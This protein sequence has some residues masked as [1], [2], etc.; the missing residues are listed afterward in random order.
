HVLDTL[1]S[2]AKSFPGHFLPYHGKES[3]EKSDGK[4]SNNVCSGGSSSS[5][6]AAGK[7]SKSQSS[8]PTDFWELLVKLDSISV[9]RKGKG[10]PRTHSSAS[11]S[12][13]EE[14][15]VTSLE[16]SAL[17]QLIQQL[18]HPVVRRSSLLTDRLLR[19][20]ALISLGLPETSDNSS[21]SGTT[22][23]TTNTASNNTQTSSTSQQQI[24]E[25]SSTLEHL[26][27]LAIQVLT[28]KSC[29]E[30]GLED[31]TAL[32]LH[33]SH[34]PP[35]ARDQ[36]LRLLL[37]GAATLGS[38]VATHI[39]ALL[40]DLKAHN[41][42]HPAPPHDEELITHLT[43]KNKKGL[44]QDRFTNECVIISGA[45]KVKPPCELQLA[46][47]SS[48]TS[49]TSSQAFFLR[50]LKVIIQLRDAIRLS[51][52]RKNVAQTSSSNS[53][54]NATSDNQPLTS[55]EQPETAA[56]TDAEGSRNSAQLSAP[57]SVD[58]PMQ[59]ELSAVQVQPAVETLSLQTTSPEIE[60]QSD[61]GHLRSL[62]S[63]PQEEEQQPEMMTTPAVTLD[64]PI[65]VADSAAN[66]SAMPVED[67]S[68][69]TA[70]AMDV[71]VEVADCSD[72]GSL[73]AQ[74]CLD[75]LWSTLSECLVELG[76]TPDTHAVLVLQP[77]VEAFFLVHASAASGE[78][79]ER[80]T[81]QSESREAQLAHLQHE[82]AP[83]S[84]LPSFPVE[85]VEGSS[86]TGG[87][88]K[89]ES[90]VS[91]SEISPDD[92]DKF[93]KF[94]EKHRT[95]LNQILRQSTVHLA[96]GPFS[97][98]VDH[99]RLLDFDIKRKYFRTELERADDGMRREDLAVHVRREHVFED[100]FREL[101][102]RSPDEWKNRFYIVFEGEEGQDA[103]GLLREWYMIISR[104]IF[105]PMYALFCTS[106]GDRV[107]YMI[108]PASHCNSNHL[109][110][111][112][113]VG[114]V[115]A[116]AI[117]DNKL[118]ECYFTRSFY[119]HILGKMVRV[120]DME[121]EDYSFY[122]GLIYL[123]EHNVA[124]LGYELTFSTE[125]QEFGVTEVRDLKPNG[126]NIAVMEET[127]ME[128]IRLVCQMKMTG[129]IRKQL[130]AFLEGFY[131]IIPKRLISIFNEQE[132]ELLI[133]GLPTIDIDDLRTNTEYH[134]YQ[135]NSLQIQWF[136]RALRSFDQAERAKFL[137][138]VTGTSKVPLQG[139][140]ALEGM[141][142][143][144]KFQIH[145]DDR[146]TDR[147]P[148][149]HTCFNQLDLPV[150]ETYDKLR[151]Y[152]LKAIHECAEGFGF[153]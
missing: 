37:Q 133:S 144:Q 71:D 122:Q 77:A 85:D 14:Q 72:L 9:S 8:E 86:N 151:H 40:T 100:S 128:Y 10:L 146:S 68:Q 112:K 21:T 41:A 143:T 105:N 82:I 11:G 2:L 140:V 27:K 75:E 74:L 67:R 30:E 80:A 79:K 123:L 18:A 28:S 153:A 52:T 73:S 117:Y 29:S 56:E 147:L 55:Q 54:R 116:K 94:A 84:P 126:R 4:K 87:A 64:V 149:A 135:P 103:G 139:F 43:D 132:T 96:D 63:L 60:E 44:L 106:P 118:L 24:T 58:I 99:T 104:E 110:Y 88:R 5:T 124:D 78:K 26:L 66:A 6:G 111:F 35:P 141:N 33:L 150:Y 95:V 36:V 138:F 127:K 101:H 53:E 92:T 121:S 134:K 16:S 129:A 131:D 3:E 61:T 114:R 83:L 17:G 15:R 89:R 115:I 98:L 42:S 45:T 65:P 19:L 39:A 120:A 107:T 119:K 59:S 12:N 136:W 1:I 148:S 97:V 20:L 51:R 13:D 108:N 137:Q 145:R 142:G 102:R 76:E 25:N 152:L 49:K 130:N 90:S 23:N 91:L 57:A 38:T 47:M 7:T 81:T 113:F 69:A 34:G 46:S 50:T 32:L 48:L 62:P 70:E 22:T 125:V 31:A 93:L 109:S